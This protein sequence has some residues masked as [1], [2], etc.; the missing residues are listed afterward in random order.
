MASD[1]TNTGWVLSGTPKTHASLFVSLI[2]SQ[3]LLSHLQFSLRPE[4]AGHMDRLHD[5]RT[6]SHGTAALSVTP[7]GALRKVPMQHT[8]LQFR[9]RAARPPSSC[10]GHRVCTR[11][12]WAQAEAREGTSAALEG[13]V[14]PLGTAPAARAVEGAAIVL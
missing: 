5:T 8:D 11:A 14:P 2:C 9:P 3:C 4:E 7:P 12:H 6:L 13:D 1:R 10:L